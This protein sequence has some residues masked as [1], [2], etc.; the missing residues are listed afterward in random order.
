MEEVRSIFDAEPMSIWETLCRP[1]EGFYIPAYQRVYTWSKGDIGRLFENT[2]HGLH[3]LVERDDAITFL[4][5][6]IVIHDTTYETVAPHIQGQL[7]GKVKIVIDGQQRITTLLLINCCLHDEICFRANKLR[8]QED[9]ASIWISQKSIEVTS[10]LQKTFEQDMD[11]GDDEFRWYPRIIRAYVD[12]WSRKAETVKYSSPIAAY[13]HDFSKHL[14]EDKNKRSKYSAPNGD[15]ATM[16]NHDILIRNVKE[17]KDVLKRIAEAKDDDLESPSL[18]DIARS[19]NL[20]TALLNAPFP[21]CIG[22]RLE[23][24]GDLDHPTQ[25]FQEL[26][27]ILLF[28]RFLLQRVSVTLVTAKNEVYAF[29]MFEALNTTGEPLTAFETFRPLVINA[30]GLANYETSP[31]RQPMRNI[32]DFLDSYKEAEK[33]QR[34]TNRLLLPF[35]LSESGRKLAKRLSD[36][37]IYLR[38]QYDRELGSLELKREFVRHL[39]YTATFVK[40]AWPDKEGGVPDLVGVKY[41]EEP[42]VRMC[43]DVLRRAKHEIAIAP[44]IRFF[45]AVRGATGDTLEHA[46]RELEAAVKAVTAF[47]TLWR[48]TRQSTD[49]IDSYYRQLM[50]E[51][52]DEVEVRAFARRPESGESGIVNAESLRNVF[53]H[54]LRTKGNIS[55]KEEFVHRAVEGR[56][57][58]PSKGT[59]GL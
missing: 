28:A 20:Q 44:L 32:E 53:R 39:A 58:S 7:P 8:T 23:L 40:H 51:G 1:G 46:S 42:V 41:S 48:S 11:H 57:C 31:S 22:E 33:K 9:P 5:T 24:S 56:V 52:F 15:E 43:L 19:E 2:T 45:S 35:A 50:K 6:V 37:R 27:R 18:H 17:I 54:I 30:E 13:L 21:D 59:A 34:A 55:S 16:A 49:N 4:G 36:Q 3:L 14:R 25:T 47:F 29:D 12:S 10:Q 26:I 38:D